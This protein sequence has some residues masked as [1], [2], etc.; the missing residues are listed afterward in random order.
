[1]SEWAP[2]RGRKGHGRVAPR[3]EAEVVYN[4]SHSPLSKSHFSALGLGLRRSRSRAAASTAATSSSVAVTPRA[5]P[6]MASRS[7]SL[8]AA[9]RAS[10]FSPPPPPPL[11]N[12]ANNAMMSC[13]PPSARVFGGSTRPTLAGP[14]AAAYEIRRWDPL[15]ES[16][17]F[18]PPDASRRPVPTRAARRRCRWCRRG[19]SSK[20]VPTKAARCNGEPRASHP[21][22]SEAVAA[23]LT[24]A[25]TATAND[26]ATRILSFVRRECRARE[27]ARWRLQAAS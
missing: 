12:D 27:A 13:A 5:E 22:L 16:A 6:A 25:E 14:V 10:F 9:R 23:G 24:A 7:A 20:W 1:M 4:S 8:A 21:L 19:V 26:M 15:V 2:P 18:T 3:M 17:H 11:K